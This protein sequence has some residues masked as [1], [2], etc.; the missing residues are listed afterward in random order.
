MYT[1]FKRS[2]PYPDLMLFDCPD[3]SVGTVQRGVSNTPLQALTLLNGE[4]AVEADRELARRALA[5]GLA[6]NGETVRWLFRACLTRPPTAMEAD[7][8]SRL[9]QTNRQWYASHAE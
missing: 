9:L 6:S 1:F 8:L 5:E 2:V 7:R 4:T 3:A